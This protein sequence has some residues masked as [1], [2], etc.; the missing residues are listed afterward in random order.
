[1]IRVHVRVECD[2]VG[3]ERYVDGI[4]EASIGIAPFGGPIEYGPVTVPP[5]A[6]DVHWRWFRSDDGATLCPVHREVCVEEQ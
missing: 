3:C 4:A 1:M 5:D 2:A 6:E